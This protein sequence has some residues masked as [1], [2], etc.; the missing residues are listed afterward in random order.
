MSA[1]N[2][3]TDAGI[4][5][6]AMEARMRKRRASERRFRAYGR[7]AV[8]FSMAALAWLLISIAAT[9][10]SAF[11][12][13][14]VTLDLTLTSQNGDVSA[15][16]RRRLADGLAHAFDVPANEETRRELLQIISASTATTNIRSR[17]DEG[18]SIQ[19]VVPTSD[20]AD[21]YLKGHIDPALPQ[22]QRKITDRQVGWIMALG[23][24]GRIDRRFNW[25]LF[26]NPDSRD[27]E[28]AGLASAIF[29]SAMIVLIAGAFALPVGI[30]AAIYL[31][32]F[33]PQTGWGGRLTRFVEVNINNLAAVPSIVF[34][35]LG[36]AVFINF[37]GLQRS[38][39]LVGGLVLALR[40]FPTI[41]IA[42][43]AALQVVPES[44]TDGALS[45]GASPMQAV[46]GHRVPLAA[47]GMLTGSIIGMA[48][49]LGETAP[50]L[51]IG[52][53]AFVTSVPGSP[54]DPA[55]ALPVQIFLW[56]GS[57]EAA[58]AERTSAA[59]I[60]LLA[61]LM[62]INGI[63]IIVRERLQRRR[64]L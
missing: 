5:S 37:F 26:G 14:W 9:G 34:G 8:A 33:A 52:M 50:L 54:M 29:G 55:T 46:F 32:S 17:S 13:H 53:V 2:M 45:L 25:G 24:E 51:M 3:D 22:D 19:L 31:D 62:I 61:I 58:W 7:A 63:A 39:P 40:M 30:G 56:S 28:R 64:K 44:L 15:N 49:A 43:R 21:Q 47:P 41:V 42:S 16:D 35:L 12:Q 59:I 38:I 27:P 6:S 57:A 18:G 1:R 36:L 20:L 48:Q 10:A 11:T 4:A 23:E 60:I